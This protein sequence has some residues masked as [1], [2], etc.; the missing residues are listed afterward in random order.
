MKSTCPGEEIAGLTAKLDRSIP[1]DSPDVT[2]TDASETLPAFRSNT[3]QEAEPASF[4]RIWGPAQP[5]PITI[6]TD[7]SICTWSTWP[8]RSRC[9]PP[10]LPVRR[11]ATCSTET[12]ETARSRSEPS[13][14]ALTTEA[15]AWQQSWGD[16]DNDGWI[17]LYVTAYGENVFYRNNGDGTFT[18]RTRETGLGG[19]PGYW[20]GASWGDYNQDGWLDLYVTGYVKYVPSENNRQASLQY[21]IE[22][23][24]SINPSSFDPERNLLYRNEGDGSF[25]EVGLALGRCQ[26]AGPKPVGSLGRFRCRWVAL[27]STSPTMYRTMC[28]T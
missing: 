7:G 22:S 14:Q 20:A 16:Y 4:L 2:F 23:P 26:S 27:T 3:S 12:T 13:K 15:G 6:T 19:I 21:D 25:T 5:G 28:C 11:R 8:A 18:D 1:D 17:D 24:A 10:K 9:R